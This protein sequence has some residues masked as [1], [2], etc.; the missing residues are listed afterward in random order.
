[1]HVKAN[2]NVY[3]LTISFSL[4]SFFVFN[5]SLLLCLGK[6]SLIKGSVINYKT[7]IEI[8]G[9]INPPASYKRLPVEAPI[10][11]PIDAALS[12]TP[13]IYTYFSLYNNGT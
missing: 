8:N 13:N 5:K 4:I 6:Y 2:P 9:N 1:M 7:P 3:L 12:T 10:I 11:Y